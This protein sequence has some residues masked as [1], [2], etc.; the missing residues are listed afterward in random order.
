MRRIRI[1]D[2]ARRAGVSR[3]SV[4]RVI[5]REAYVS[6]DLRRKVEKVIAQLNY[7]PDRQARSLRSGRAFQL[8]FA[9]ESPSS[10]YVISLIEGIRSACHREGYELILHETETKGSRLLL[11]VLEFVDRSRLD[12]LL[13]MPPLTDNEQLLAA[14]DDAGIRYGRVSPG[15]PRDNG[16]DVHTTDRAA[17]RAV[18]DHLL[19]LGHRHIAFVS[20]HPDHL[21]M[22]ARLQGV[23]DSL[24]AWRGEPCDL[25]VSQGFSTFDSGLRV[26]D[27]LL[28]LDPRPTAIFAA[29]DDMAAGVLFEV[30]ERG[31]R[32]PDDISIAGFDDTLLAAHVWP[33][34]TTVR[35]PVR[36]MGEIVA[37]NLIDTVSGRKIEHETLI[38]A[39]LILRRSSGPPPRAPSKANAP[40]S[41]PGDGG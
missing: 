16:L 34:L 27:G 37:Q 12:G 15:Q 31:L 17:G 23:N 32:V 29:N 28:N 10:Y 18:A 19:M 24:S 26:A 2:V 39:E 35:Q 13:M 40:G 33:G 36:R 5:N 21:A 1:S 3:K 4:S 9:Y 8:G 7:E 6:D 22:A 11:S 30:Q 25:V 41:E 20:G 38:P 14:L